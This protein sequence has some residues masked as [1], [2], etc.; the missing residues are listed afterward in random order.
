MELLTER[1]RRQYLRESLQK[2]I[3][4]EQE[5]RRN[6]LQRQLYAQQVF[7]RISIFNGFH[8]L[9]FF[10]FSSLYFCS[11]IFFSSSLIFGPALFRKS[12]SNSS[13]S[14]SAYVCNLT[15]LLTRR[16]ERKNN[17]IIMF[18]KNID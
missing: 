17:P 8:F 13:S 5:N 7:T 15:Q 14:L 6:E 10:P 2:Q 12:S 18:F 1:Q 11:K 4:K 9:R 3:L 16:N